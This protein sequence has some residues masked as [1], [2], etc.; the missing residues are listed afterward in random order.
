M[1]ARLMELLIAVLP[2][3]LSGL[4]GSYAG[5]RFS[6][7]ALRAADKRL[8]RREAAA[9]LSASLRDLRSMSRS[10][11]RV[12][13]DQREVASAM[14]AWFEAFD[15]HWQRLPTAWR[16]V[17]RSVRGAVG[18]VFGGVAMVDLRPEMATC[19]LEGSDFQWQEFA[20]DYLT[21]VVDA[22]ARWADGDGLPRKLRSFDSWLDVTG[23]RPRQPA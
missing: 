21:Y 2:G 8:A 4:T 11:G 18:E 15:R 14:T 17:G 3:V 10:L 22:V 12:E 9:D 16:H 7:R 13:L 20:D 19:P 1:H 6:G 5:Y 23:R